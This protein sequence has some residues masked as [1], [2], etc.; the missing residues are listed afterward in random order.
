[1]NSSFIGCS[2]KISIVLGKTSTCCKN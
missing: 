2:N 1:V